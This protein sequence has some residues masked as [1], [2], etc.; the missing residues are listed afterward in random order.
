M[1]TKANPD[2][3]LVARLGEFLGAIGGA[4]RKIA[5]RLGITPQ[6][7]NHAVKGKNYLGLDTLK[8]LVKEY[9]LNVN[10]L[11][12]GSGP[13]FTDGP[14]A[15]TAKAGAGGKA[16]AGHAHAG[17]AFAGAHQVSDSG[18]PATPG[19]PPPSGAVDL[20]VLT[21]CIK[22][23][24]RALR[25]RHKVMDPDKKA[26]VVSALYDL[27]M[28]AGGKALPADNLVRFIKASGG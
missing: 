24:E 2:K 23:V 27:C 25:E 12:M 1:A 15:E 22:A 19:A 28:E 10:W 4:E 8:R 14:A 17:Q 21:E 7:L 3:D 26:E 9:R 20:E 13:M 6:A 5:I 11:L 18:S 16:F